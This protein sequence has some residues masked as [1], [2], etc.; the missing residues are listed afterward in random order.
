MSSEKHDRV[1]MKLA[2]II[3]GPRFPRPEAS[4]EEVERQRDIKWEKATIFERNE[5][6][7]N[8]EAILREMHVFPM[9]ES[10]RK[11]KPDLRIV[12]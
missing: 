7:V 1:K 12:K 4:S 2:R 10:T 11:S 6:L 3:I 8:A 5:A 9:S